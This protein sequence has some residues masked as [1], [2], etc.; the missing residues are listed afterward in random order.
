[1]TPLFSTKSYKRA[2]INWYLIAGVVVVFFIGTLLLSWYR[3]IKIEG[4]VYVQ[5]EKGDT[6]IVVVRKL[7]RS[8]IRLSPTMFRLYYK[9]M[10]HQINAG[11]YYLKSPLSI[12]KLVDILSK[13]HEQGEKVT[14]PEGWTYKKITELLEEKG[15]ITDRQQFMVLFDNTEFIRSLGINAPTLE[16]YVYPDTYYL[17]KNMKPEDIVKRMYEQ[18]QVKIAA[19]GLEKSIKESKF[20]F[21]ELMTLAS[22]VEWEYQAAEEQPIIAQVFL[23]RLEIGQPLES[24]ATVLYALGKHKNYLLYSDLEVKSPFNTYK[25]A[26]LPPTPINSPGIASIQAVLNPAKTDYLYFI[27]KNDGT[28]YFSKTYE[29]HLRARKQ[30]PSWKK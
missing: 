30:Y 14:V 1:M 27:S 5:I 23:K 3:P 7:Q 17:S 6:G 29:E 10:P 25:V 24:C 18:L 8:G 16:G 21:H 4:V 11:D 22:I 26:G 12:A 15:I 9:I 28:H 2:R 20:T 13:G 19:A